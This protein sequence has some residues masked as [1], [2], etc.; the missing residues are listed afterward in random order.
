MRYEEID[1]TVA[2]NSHSPGPV[3]PDE[4]L[5]R[6]GFHPENF[7]SGA[8][9]S[10]ILPIEHLKLK[11]PVEKSGCSVDRLAFSNREHVKKKLLDLAEHSQHVREKEVIIQF[12]CCEIRKI[13]DEGRCQAF[14]VLDIAFEYD[15]SHAAIMV[16]REY[17]DSYLRKLRNVIL[18][19]WRT[20]P[21]KTIS[22]IF[23]VEAV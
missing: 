13:Q 2:F 9:A 4:D 8:L 17:K 22:D 11:N 15:R 3:M 1:E 12:K 21:L 20:K 6:C 14:K 18:D 5:L 23:G 19:I 10:N 16:A 7:D